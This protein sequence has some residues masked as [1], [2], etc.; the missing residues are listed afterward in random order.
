MRLAAFVARMGKNVCRALVRKPEG[1]LRAGI[2]L[3]Q[4]ERRCY[5]CLT[6]MVQGC[7]APGSD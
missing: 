5:V 7:V 3:A 2:S 4:V 1:K 6:E